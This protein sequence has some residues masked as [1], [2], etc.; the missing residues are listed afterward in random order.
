MAT[1]FTVILEDKPGR[2]AGLCGVLGDARVN[3]EAIQGTRRDGK[4]RVQFLPRAP[5]G[6]Q[7]RS[8]QLASRI[9]CAKW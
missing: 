5:V 9:Q 6:R 8:T 7:L 2:L 4:S 3:I 1:E